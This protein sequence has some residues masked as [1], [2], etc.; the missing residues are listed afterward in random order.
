MEGT[1]FKMSKKKKT[2]LPTIQKV[3]YKVEKL[4]YLITLKVHEKKK[5]MKQEKFIFLWARKGF[6]SSL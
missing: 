6:F 1:I 2:S 4:E 3:K 5:K